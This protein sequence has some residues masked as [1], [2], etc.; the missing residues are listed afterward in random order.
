MACSERSPFVVL[1]AQRSVR[2]APRCA[3]LRGGPG[4]DSPDV[5]VAVS[6]VGADVGALASA[7]HLRRS[8]RRCHGGA[9]GGAVERS[10]QDLVPVRRAAGGQWRRGSAP[11]SVDRLVRRRLRPRVAALDGDDSRQGRDRRARA[12]GHG[13]GCARHGSGHGVGLRRRHTR[14]LVGGRPDP[15]CGAVL[16]GRLRRLRHRHLRCDRAAALRRPGPRAD[17]IDVAGRLPT[18]PLPH[19]GCRLDHAG[20]HRAATSGHRSVPL[21]T[22]AGA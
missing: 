10:R 22:D 7:V 4:A 8:H 21:T 17:R 9:V 1:A 20:G 18:G 5:V 14:A 16:L 11:G 19:R 13:I 3:D 12:S 15:R 2:A 6:G